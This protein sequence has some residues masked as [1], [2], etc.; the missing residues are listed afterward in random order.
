M[1]TNEEI[2]KILKKKGD[3]RGVVF[4]TDADYILKQAEAEG[5]SKVEEKLKEWGV[6]FIYRD[7]KP[8]AWYPVAW[9]VLSL[10]A[11][12]E[13]FGWGDEDIKK[14]GE[15]AP[16]VSIIVKLFFKLFPDIEKFAE[17]VPKYWRKHYT[18]GELEVVK[19][20]KESKSMLLRLKDF[21]FHPILCK[22]YFAGYFAKT[23]QL[24]RPKGSVVT[25]TEMK[26]SMLDNTPFE[27]YKIEWTK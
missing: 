15:N 3:V 6:N 7:I 25:C 2:E 20:H 12:K 21:S 10:L 5:L 14:M 26:C 11:A 17:Q 24:T 19:L 4:Q 8:M 27:E 16:K 13:S 1:P 18:S 9:R 22:H 23:V